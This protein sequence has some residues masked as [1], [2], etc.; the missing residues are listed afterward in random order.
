VKSLYQ[1]LSYYGGWGLNP[2]DWATRE[3]S[4]RAPRRQG[5]YGNWGSYQTDM[6]SEAL[7]ERPFF[8]PYRR[9]LV[10]SGPADVRDN[11]Y[12]SNGSSFV[13]GM[14][15]SYGV[16]NR[17]RFLAKM[18]PAESFS[19]GANEV[20]RFNQNGSNFD[21]QAEGR[22]N[23]TMWVVGRPDS[24]WKHSDLREVAYV[25]TKKTFDEIVT[26]G[27]LKNDN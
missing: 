17:D 16:T 4:S 19:V 11:L 26:L 25:F 2:H 5:G 6:P 7:K 12:G 15:S 8:N 18:I 24:F 21:M 27:G 1:P 22:T 13:S 9:G 14:N 3:R 20:I 23:Q 10:L